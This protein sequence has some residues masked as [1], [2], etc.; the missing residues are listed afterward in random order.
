MSGKHTIELS[1]SKKNRMKTDHV[2]FI[3]KRHEY[4]HLTADSE[5]V[6]TKVV[7]FGIFCFEMDFNGY[8]PTLLHL[9]LQNDSSYPPTHALSSSDSGIDQTPTN[10]LA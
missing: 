10:F 6:L 8:F 5:I 2:N 9:W 7:D 4:S 1:Q 3:P